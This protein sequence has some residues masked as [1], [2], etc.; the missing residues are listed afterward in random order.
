MGAL[1]GDQGSR[2]GGFPRT[3]SR[4]WRG[5]AWV[6]PRERGLVSCAVLP[7]RHLRARGRVPNSWYFSLCRCS[8]AFSRAT[9]RAELV[10]DR[11]LAA[12]PLLPAA[13]FDDW[14]SGILLRAGSTV[15]ASA[16]SSGFSP[17]TRALA[18]RGSIWA[19]FSFARRRVSD[20]FHLADCPPPP[21]R[22]PRPSSYRDW[23]VVFRLCELVICLA[24]KLSG[25]RG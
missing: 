12:P 9:C 22:V 16:P 21:P 3:Q 25:G 10:S 5:S 11:E 4:V 15:V 8:N 14:L 1:I 18:G 24:T 7:I 6:R 20:I 2:F 17:G 13:F 19:L 23:C